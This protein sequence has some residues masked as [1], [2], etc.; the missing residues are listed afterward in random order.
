MSATVV[1]ISPRGDRVSCVL[2]GDFVVPR[3]VRREGRS[4]E[5]AL[6]AGRAMLLPGDAVRIEISV[7]EGCTLSLVD[8]GG[9]VVYGRAGETGE[10][11]H[12]HARADLADGARLRWQGLPTVITDAGHLRRSLTVRLAAGSSATLHETLV[13]GRSGERGGRVTAQT[14]AADAVGPIL[15]DTLEVSGAEPVPGVLGTDRIVDSILTLGDQTHVPEVP[16]AVRLDFERGGV[17]LRYLGDALHESPLRGAGIGA[18]VHE[19]QPAA[20][21]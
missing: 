5:V 11:S 6:V 17:M 2:A 1:D 18:V 20:V 4:V 10:P 19:R 16:G 12:W 8:I 9:L 13:L 15:R 14:D 3:L 21:R 7:G